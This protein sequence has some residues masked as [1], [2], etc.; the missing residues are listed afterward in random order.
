MNLFDGF[1]NFAALRQ[2]AKRAVRGKRRKPGASGF[3]A[4]LEKELL[5]LERDLRDGSYRPG[6]H[7]TIRISDPKERIVSA[8]PFR[9]RVVHH[10]LCA[11][12]Q[13][14]FERGFIDNS[15]ANR[16]EKGTHKAIEV[17]ER[18]RDRHRFVLR[19]DI[20]RYF[21]AID[22]QILK[23]DFRRRIGCNHTLALLDLIVDG[24]GAQESVEIHFPG[25][26]LFAPS[27][28]RRGLPLGNLTSQF[29]ANLYLDRFDHFVADRRA[30]WRA[31]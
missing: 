16:A 27:R 30:G 28:R 29:F 26:D 2:A 20:F 13:P 15:F 18:Y 21:P 10:A 19:G 5:R 1:A 23:A 25:D 3:M 17:Y 24:S 31:P 8:A 6:R 14:I 12:I 7:V 4:N 22:H 9:D 11:A